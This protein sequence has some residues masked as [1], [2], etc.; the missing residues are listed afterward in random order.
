[1][2]MAQQVT[3]SAPAAESRTAPRPL[4]SVEQLRKLPPDGRPEF[5]RLVFEKSPY[6]LQHARNPV[7]WFPWGDA[8]FEQARKEDKPVFL[9]IGYSTCHWCH[10]MEHE[11]FEDTD[12]ARLL[13]DGFICI[14]VDREERPD[15]DNVYM[16]VCQATTGRGGWP[17]TIVMTP[18]KKPFFAGTYFPKSARFG[19]QGLVELLPRLGEAW[20]TQREKLVGNADRIVQHLQSAGAR[21]PAA[22]PGVE[23]LKTGYRQLADRFDAAHGGFGA[24]PKFPT[25]HNLTFLLRYWRRTG[26]ENA[27]KIVRQTLRAMRAGGIYDHIGFGFHRYSTDAE[28]LVPHFEKMLYDQ[29]LL[30]VAYVETF[31]ATHEAEFAQTAREI[32]TYVLRDMTAPEGAFYSAEDAD[33]EGVEGK[34][35]LWT[36]DELRRALGEQ[37]ADLIARAFGVKADGNFTNPHTPPRTNILH[38]S[39]TTAELARELGIEEP[40]A[41]RRLEAARL[42]LFAMREQRVRPHKDDKILTDWNGLM[43]VALAKAARV[44][45]EPKYATAAQRAA[46]FVL[47]RLRDSRGRLLKRFRDGE[48]GL[49]AHL[50]DYAF[51]V[52]GLLELYESSF[53]VRNL[54]AALELNREMLRHYW[55]DAVGGLFFTADDG[56]ALLART[57]EVYDGA[58]PSGNSVAMLNLLR[59]ARITGDSALE[60]KTAAISRTFSADLSRAPSAHTQFLGALDFALGPSFEIVIAGD[61]ARDDTREMLRTLRGI[62]LPNAVVLLRPDGSAGIT[63][64][65]EFT[66]SQTAV[67]GKATAYV[68]VNHACQ[69]PT[70]D[71][72][73]LVKQLIPRR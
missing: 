72:H 15:I 41:V 53:E 23:T 45:D 33:S 59:I 14:K 47:D 43:I 70:T 42:K 28:W 61:P 10:V 26:D 16:S 50:D 46:D 4:P 37:D 3:S 68:C 49:P 52:W 30:A 31:Q 17:L 64:I 29:A 63:R 1:M 22:E 40:E 32:L 44:L 19:R 55:D 56:E 39:G 60:D 48:A 54:Q 67:D 58:L 73:E 51:L 6:L 18:D 2:G 24:A 25:P 21:A 11:S 62:F 65:A 71:R 38:R 35:Y 66:Q 69:A 20:R 34:F 27:L 12:V 9:S 57:K 7:N 36:A 13:N 5:N 8:A